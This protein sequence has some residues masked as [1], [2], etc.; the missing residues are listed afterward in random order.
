MKKT[1]SILSLISLG[2]ALYAGPVTPEKALQVAQSVFASA[3]G[4]KAA[5]ESELKIGFPVPRVAL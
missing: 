2:C 4:T 3:P 5:G 1:F